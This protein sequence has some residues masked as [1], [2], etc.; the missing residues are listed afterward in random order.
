MGGNEYW[1]PAVGGLES[2]L[3]VTEAPATAYIEEWTQERDLFRAGITEDSQA[4]TINT[5]DNDGS[6]HR[7]SE[8]SSDGADNGT[9]EEMAVD[10]DG[11]QHRAGECGSDG[12]DE[13]A[14]AVEEVVAQLSQDIDGIRQRFKSRELTGRDAYA[15]FDRV[16]VDYLG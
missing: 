5:V 3:F 15:N 9:A 7:A 8:C 12:A 2:K 16:C 1:A 11:S 10:D 14:G 13:M 6:P 4:A